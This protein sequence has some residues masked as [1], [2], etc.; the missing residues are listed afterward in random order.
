MSQ[1]RNQPQYAQQ[2]TQQ[3][4]PYQQGAP[5]P[6][7]QPAQPQQIPVTDP[8]DETT[9]LTDPYVLPEPLDD[10]T[11]LLDDEYEVT[12]ETNKGYNRE[13]DVKYVAAA[14]YEIDDEVTVH[15]SQTNNNAARQQAQ[16][17]GAQ[18]TVEANTYTLQLHYSATDE[19]MMHEIDDTLHER[20]LEHTVDA[21]DDLN[22][23][24]YW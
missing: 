9:I 5:Q 1:D 12:D 14:D 19:D 10:I 17:Q 24:Y 3:Q 23:R 21:D 13:A 2:N 20:I 18:P 4:A 8:D 15:W 22:P 11:E 16:A 7:P 6:Q